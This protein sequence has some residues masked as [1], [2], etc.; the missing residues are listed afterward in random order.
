M[1][2]LN[3]TEEIEAAEA[4]EKTEAAPEAPVLQPPQPVM[5]APQPVMQAHQ[6]AVQATQPVA[7]P[8]PSN[9]R[10]RLR[11]YGVGML[12][13]PLTLIT[14]GVT[15]L[16]TLIADG[17]PMNVVKALPLA[18]VYLGLEIL[19]NLFIRRSGKILLEQNS[20]IFTTGI[21]F[22]VL[23]LSVPFMTG[24]AGDN[25]AQLDARTALEQSISA[26]ATD[27]FKTALAASEYGD[28][29][30]S[31]EAEAAVNGLDTDA[32]HSIDDLQSG[33]LINVTITLRETPAETKEFVAICR[34][35]IPAVKE[36]GVPIN[37]LMFICDDMFDRMS[38]TLDGTFELD[39]SAEKMEKLVG[40]AG[41]SY[42][43]E[44]EDVEDLEE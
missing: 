6:S 43:S 27:K 20:M 9:K 21:A 23:C 39:L 17:S 19:F 40:Y 38:L 35:L 31:V 16:V 10:P 2:E 24:N 36:A 33:D 29:I 3:F 4:E 37:K 15:L 34:E 28:C 11:R 13:A 14:L 22:V 1:D 5:Q 41:I 26:Q 44:Q 25:T 18:L 30:R 8:S 32:Y 42:Y 7:P 12:T